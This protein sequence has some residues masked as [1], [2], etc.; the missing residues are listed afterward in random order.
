MCSDSSAI[1]ITPGPITLPWPQY[2]VIPFRCSMVADTLHLQADCI[3]LNQHNGSVF[4]YGDT[5][6]ILSVQYQCIHMYQ[7]RH[8]GK[9]VKI[10]EVRFVMLTP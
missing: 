9:L 1:P 5:L 3:T 8:D 7:I 6:A 10:R 2:G 4:L